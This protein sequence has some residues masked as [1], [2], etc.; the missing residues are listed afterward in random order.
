MA[1]TS[2]S[3]NEPQTVEYY[4]DHAGKDSTVDADS[5]L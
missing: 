4:I 1:A 5:R 2:Q 3:S